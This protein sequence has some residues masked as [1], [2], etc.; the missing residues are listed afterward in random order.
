MIDTHC[1]ILPMCDDGPENWDQAVEMAKEAVRQGITDVIATPHH[2][3]ANYINWPG[4]IDMLVVQLNDRLTANGI[5]LTVWPGQEYHLR[6]GDNWELGAIHPLGDSKYVLLELPSKQTP[7]NWRYA[8]RS[9][10]HAGYVPI[11]AHPERHSPFVC[12]PDK[13]LEWLDA[14]AYFQLTAP[15]LLGQYGKEIQQAASL[16]V[17]NG[18]IHLLASDAHDINGR[19]HKLRD[20][21]EFLNAVVGRDVVNHLNS[22]AVKMLAGSIMDDSRSGAQRQASRWSIT[23]IWR[24]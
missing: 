24:K 7:P 6:T 3:K 1:H 20:G 11:I 22:N 23:T 15:S 5:A 14:G 17:T 12:K 8:L 10:R 13:M 19:S 21:F 18:W 2:G 16:M 4:K 9:V